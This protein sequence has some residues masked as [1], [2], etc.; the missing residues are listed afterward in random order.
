METAHDP[1]PAA[2]QALRA[3]V[4]SAL[5]DLGLSPLDRGK[6]VMLPGALPAPGTRAERRRSHSR[7]RSTGVSEDMRRR[8]VWAF[9][10]RRLVV[11]TVEVLNTNVRRESKLPRGLHVESDFNELWE[12]LDTTTE[13]F[14]EVPLFGYD[15]NGRR[16]DLKPAQIAAIMIASRGSVSSSMEMRVT[17]QTLA[18]AG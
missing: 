7:H 1:Y 11:P 4:M 17:L 6:M 12:L 8:D 3:G 15:E 9:Q 5:S 14:R 10:S 13:S 2:L 18:T 16:F